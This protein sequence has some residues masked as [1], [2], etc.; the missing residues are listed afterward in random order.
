MD[1]K[2]AFIGIAAVAAALTMAAAASWTLG[3]SGNGTI[4]LSGTVEATTSTLSF[5]VGGY[6]KTV[7][8]DEGD[9]VKKGAVLAK[10]DTE[11]LK[12]A[13]ETAIGE[14]IMAAANLEEMEKGSRPEEI[15]AASADV[16]K[17]KAALAEMEGGSRVQ[18]IAEAQARLN[19]AVAARR[20]AEATLEMAKADDE[21]FKSLYKSGSIG[22][23]EYES[24]RTAYRNAQEKLHE[25]RASV[26]AA[27]QQLSLLKEG[28]RREDVQQAYAA[29]QGAQARYDLV[30]SG[31]REE[32]KAQARARLRAAKA[33]TDMAALKLGY[34]ELRA[35]F[36]GTVLVKAS[37]EGE[38]VSPGTPAFS[39]ARL[40]RP[41]I[42]C[43]VMETDLSHIALGQSAL[44]EVD[45]LDRGI[46]GKVTYISS[47]AEFTPKTVETRKERVNLM[48]RIKVRGDNDDGVLKIGMPV[49]VRI[50][51]R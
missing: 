43:F 38:N 21:R 4:S 50:T 29:L 18:Q 10:L 15:A 1:K 47:Q 8:V 30:R 45:G 20:S 44:V 17:A 42:R 16:Q 2:R 5:R 49:T 41:W 3:K 25:A 27:S 22:Q 33:R 39:L 23:R 14:Q 40:D 9:R 48:Y 51:P 35:P 28:S 11:D 7:C 13:L 31:P 12:L 36:D 26:S 24:Y 19:Q 46:E 37:E 32:V 34:A 6:V